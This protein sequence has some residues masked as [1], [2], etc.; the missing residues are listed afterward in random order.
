MVRAVFFLLAISASTVLAQNCTTYVVVEPFDTKT[1]HGIDNLKTDNFEAK[2]GGD[3]LAIVSATQNFNSRVLVLVETRGT[4]EDAGRKV[5]LLNAAAA[6]ARKEPAGRPIAF[7]VFAEEAFIMKDFLE[8]RQKRSAAIDEILTQAVQLPGKAPAVFDSL[9]QALAAFGPHQRGDTI[10]LLSD[11]H[12]H[13]SKRNPD[14]LTKEFMASG[15]R[16]VVFFHDGY[17]AGALDHRRYI[18]DENRA[19]K[20]LSSR[21][22]GMYAPYSS[23]RALEFAWAGYMLGIQI[24]AAWNKPKD[25]K[26]QIRDS[27]GKTDK[28]VFF[29]LPWKLPPCNT[30]AT[31]AH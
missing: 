23:A 2:A 30:V 29:A 18:R 19:L 1:T 11:F 13:S 15:T 31:A 10:V 24:P 16:L 7:G 9:H 17:K 8:D 6:A 22:G 4:S 25:W 20:V 5:L 28:D 21:T 27:N 14:D 26:L 3:S 12:D